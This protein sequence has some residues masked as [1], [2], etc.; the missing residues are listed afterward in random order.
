MATLKESIAV[1]YYDTK[2]SCAKPVNV[3]ILLRGNQ[4]RLQIVKVS[5]NK[6]EIK[7]DIDMN[8]IGAVIR[9][10]FKIKRYV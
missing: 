7:K 4:P 10:K 1:E 8:N 6:Y 5:G 2:K 9:H 3:L